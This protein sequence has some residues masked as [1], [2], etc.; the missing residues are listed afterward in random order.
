MRFKLFL[1]L[2]VI[3]LHDAIRVLLI[4]NYHLQVYHG[5]FAHFDISRKLLPVKLKFIS[6]TINQVIYLLLD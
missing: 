4:G 1:L 5:L 2:V 3:I 6:Q